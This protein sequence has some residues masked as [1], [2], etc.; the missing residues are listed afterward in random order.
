M[1]S[2]IAFS[3]LDRLL[4][5]RDMNS[6]K[7]PFYIIESEG[8]SC[9]KW[10]SMNPEELR[11]NPIY[12]NHK[13]SK[14]AKIEVLV[15][16]FGR[17]A[18]HILVSNSKESLTLTFYINNIDSIAFKSS[19]KSIYVNSSSRTFSLIGKDKENNTFDS[20]EGLDFS[21]MVD[22]Y[23]L[24]TLQPSDYKIKKCDSCVHVQG[25]RVGNT[26]INASFN[27]YVT[28]SI[29][30]CVIDPIGLFP[31][32]Y[33]T[34]L[35]NTRI[36]LK[37][38]S[39]RGFDN[40]NSPRIC[41]DAI[42]PEEMH[43]YNVNVS[44]PE[45]IEFSHGFIFNA[46][47]RGVSSVMVQEIQSPDNIATVLIRV[48]YPTKYEMPEQYISL[49]SDPEFNP[50]LYGFDGSLMSPPKNWNVEGNWST[51]GDHIV[52]I[53]YYDYSIRTII[54]VREPLFLD[55][56]KLVLPVGIKL[57]IPIRGGSKQ[58]KYSTNVT[59]IIEIQNS[60]LSTIGTGFVSVLIQDINI[61]DFLAT[62]YIRVSKVSRISIGMM[63]HEFSTKNPV[64]PDC[65]GVSDENQEFSYPIQIKI[66]SSNES[67]LPLSMIANNPGFSY[68]QCY[69]ENVLSKSIK[70]AVFKQ[71]SIKINNI[72]SPD[73]NI[74]L[75]VK[76]GI[77][78]WKATDDIE[79]I[80]R[81]G[82]ADVKVN[83]KY[84]ISLSEP[85][86]GT[87]E[88]NFRNKISEENPNPITMSA[89]FSLKV[90]PVDK[91]YIQL[92]HDFLNMP[93]YCNFPKDKI[94]TNQN[95]TFYIIKG[96]SYQ[97]KV[98]AY[99]E[100]NQRIF[101][102][103]HN[104]ISI[105]SSNGGEMGN[106]VYNLEEGYLSMLFIPT[107]STDIIFRKNN[108]I[109]N[110]IS[111]Q[112]IPL[113]KKIEPITVL[114]NPKSQI[115]GA[116]YGG[117]GH[118]KSNY[119][120]I[121]FTERNFVIKPFTGIQVVRIFDTCHHNN[122]I[123]LWIKSI[124]IDSL[125][126]ESPDHVTEGRPF[127]AKIDPKMNGEI[128]NSDYYPNSGLQI[129]NE[130]CEFKSKNEWI[131]SLN[132]VG[133]IALLAKSS[134]GI[135]TSKI[136]TVHPQIIPEVKYITMIPYEKYEIVLKKKVD[137]LKFF[138]YNE[139]IIEIK[140]TIIYA[141]SIG[142][143]EVHIRSEY[144]INSDDS[145]I[146][147]E[148]L[149]VNNFSIIAKPSVIIQGRYCLLSAVFNTAPIQYQTKSIDWI[150]PQN[151]HYI[152]VS[153]ESIMIKPLKEERVVLSAQ[154]YGYHS[155]F[156]Y[157]VL[158]NVLDNIPSEI[159]LPPGG[160]YI[161]CVFN[162]KAV[163]ISIINDY[164]KSILSIDRH[165]LTT[166]NNTGD[167]MIMFKYYYIEKVIIL[168]VRNPSR[169]IIE[170]NGGCSYKFHL[171]DDNGNTFCDSKGIEY[172]IFGDDVYHNGV[173]DFGIIE[174]RN[175]PKHCSI[176]INAKNNY[177]SI[178]NAFWIKTESGI[179]PSNPIIHRFLQYSLD[180][181][182]SVTEWATN[183]TGILSI[184]KNGTIVGK[185]IGKALVMCN[186]ESKTIVS[187]V[188]IN[189]L[190]KGPIIDNVLKVHPTFN[191]E[192]LD[193]SVELPKDLLLECSCSS[194]R[195][196]I[197]TIINYTG[198]YCILDDMGL[199]SLKYD[200]NISMKSE[201][202]R[203]KVHTFYTYKPRNDSDIITFNNTRYVISSILNSLV[204][205]IEFDKNE[206]EILKSDIISIKSANHDGIDIQALSSF[207]EE[208]MIIRI[209]KTK[210]IIRIY[211]A[212]N[213]S[214]QK[215]VQKT[216]NSIPLFMSIAGV[217]V[218]SL[219]IRKKLQE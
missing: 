154:Y 24:K 22:N 92:L 134:N 153:Y 102:F 164:S 76:D 37:L 160:K 190:L 156:G 45:V 3:K 168:K 12:D 162:N 61:P 36:D 170:P 132:S 113:I 6:K 95:S 110:V 86:D 74:P 101:Y 10:N 81:C 94:I 178:S 48:E 38:C 47:K 62:L 104:S 51:I 127:I 192:I 2:D 18:S 138:G 194:S 52:R 77:I 107:K 65:T 29:D 60:E 151:I 197:R 163:L 205:P 97:F 75:N 32:P 105:H 79:C 175:I 25:R 83:G 70:I 214:S 13:C 166:T 57:N 219:I 112:S 68:I 80:V 186:R 126:I 66:S 67:V 174:I 15:S 7:I 59:G 33:L 144:F 109:Q 43:K 128:I 145:K 188:E 93:D 106:F 26:T 161:N 193:Q 184:S 177:F 165:V 27:N 120:G 209:I 201:S 108:E 182:G 179:I 195:K 129:V 42:K 131:C 98:M 88:A 103:N 118:F 218:S 212:M 119:S 133:K 5:Y 96:A 84:F 44:H 78:A 122:D 211:L 124:S 141:K 216:S 46:R 183:N 181:I 207:E 17:I 90:V 189:G 9:L 114:Y 215:K 155:K 64:N 111:L 136:I 4:P 72:G 49:G 71:P 115:K 73:S 191:N 149:C 143:T 206:Y 16:G 82:S 198:F 196:Q 199:V 135:S 89:L 159:L 187:I 21:F 50:K 180:C 176:R 140:D 87:C 31:G 8:S 1:I 35:P 19:S 152:Q 20:L 14:S 116:L 200:I 99:Q 171:L 203:V 85:F 169:V 11:V 53:Y 208:V 157:E 150:V 63:V 39:T 91:Y 41:S 137:L 173:N 56:N 123:N 58:Y 142:Q 100:N 148:V 28:T 117:S 204:I 125:E 146:F 121:L 217:I 139:D 202:C 210:Q 30:L 34:I 213:Q 40:E 69:N 147:V 23:H 130:E 185:N 54:H 167:S 158:P 172:E 55:N